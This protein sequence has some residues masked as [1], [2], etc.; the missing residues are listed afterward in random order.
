MDDW[1]SLIG[2]IFNRYS[3]V[4]IRERTD[5]EIVQISKKEV[6][7]KDYIKKMPDE[8]D[9]WL[10]NFEEPV[11]L[12][13]NYID[14]VSKLYVVK[15]IYNFQTDLQNCGFLSKEVNASQAATGSPPKANR[16]E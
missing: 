5:F 15:P 3:F 2:L 13:R 4:E 9:P 10:S 6:Q 11:N 7:I 8:R 14:Y 12:L 1:K 16:I